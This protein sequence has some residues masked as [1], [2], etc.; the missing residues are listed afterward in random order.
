M[1]KTNNN[2]SESIAIL[3]LPFLCHW[4]WRLRRLLVAIAS[5]ALFLAAVI[6]EPCASGPAGFLATL[7]HFE[8]CASGPCAFSGVWLL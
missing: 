6:L 3:V 4:P 7:T 5:W 2:I 1:Y 8:L